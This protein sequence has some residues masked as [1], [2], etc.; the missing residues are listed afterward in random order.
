MNLPLFRH[1]ALAARSSQ[2]AGTI[3]LSRPVS[4]RIA[5]IAA[6]VLTI[7]LAL[8]LSF[9]EYTRKV[10]ATG[11]IVPAAGAL[12]AVAPQ[13]GRVIARHVQDGDLVQAGQLLYELSSERAGQGGGIDTRID[14][15]LA[16]RRELL[17]QERVL[18][19]RQSKQQQRSL[20]IR[21]QLIGAEIDRLEQEIALQQTRIAS[22]DKTLARYRSLREQGYISE[23][24]LTQ[25]ENDRSDQLGRRQA[26]ERAKLAATRDL[27]QTQ[28]ETDQITGQIRLNSAQ[29]ERTLAS[30]DQE[31]AEHQ[32]RSRMQVLAPAAGTVTALTAEPGQT[33]AAGAS[34]ATVI[35]TG[36]ALE[37]H[38]LAPSRA[39]GFI[40]PG[41]TVLLRLAA[42]PYQKFGQAS[43]TVLRVE[44]SP[45]AEAGGEA[46][47]GTNGEPV[48]R[49]AVK[50]AQQSVMAY[51]KAQPYRAGMTLEADI[52]QDRRRLIEWVIDPIISVAKGRA[53]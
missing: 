53:G 13:F 36:S 37:A 15:S 21:H 45:I 9:G 23:F 7:A 50:L 8:Y 48:Y 19:T 43:G 52:R 51:G 44:R 20:Q 1:E 2:W 14:V 33:V 5:A 18:Q 47:N 38:L 26:L 16:S 30:L 4:M 40:E 11:Q 34:L 24:Q 35:P 41:Q 27:V 12:K 25:Y 28:A 3:V 46:G 31:A 29:T 39:I 22:A 10:R 17:T 6:A 49:I 32:G 42:F